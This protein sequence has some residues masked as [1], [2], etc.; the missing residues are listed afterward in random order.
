MRLVED[1]GT[2][3]GRSGKSE[4]RGSFLCTHCDQVVERGLRDGTKAKSCGC[5]RTSVRRKTKHIY[6]AH[7][8]LFWVYHGIKSRCYNR[9]NT[10]YHRYGGRGIKMCDEWRNDACKFFEW[11]LSNGWRQGLEVDRVNNDGDYSPSNCQLVSHAVNSRKRSSTKMTYE[12]AGKLREFYRANSFTHAEVA[13]HFGVSEITAWRILNN[14][15][16]T[17]KEVA[18]ENIAHG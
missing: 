3:K 11:A 10:A 16:W 17:E 18:N 13:Q 2:R 4:R 5:A 8:K 14:K 9:N 15:I 7:P 1:L 6:D 12:L